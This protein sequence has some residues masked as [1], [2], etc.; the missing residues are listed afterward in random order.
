MPN[1][2]LLLGAIILFTGGG[3]LGYTVGH[4]QGLT[5]VGYDADAQQLVDVVKKQKDNLDNLNKAYNLAIQER[6]LA[7]GNTD[8]LTDALNN[9][10]ADLSIAQGQSQIYRN[11]LKDRGGLSLTIQNLSIQ[12]LPENA[13]EYQLDLVQASPIGRNATGTVEIR[14]VRGAEVLVVPMEDKNFNFADFSRLTGRWTMPKGFVPQYIEVRV[15]G[16]VSE[17]KRFSWLRGP[18]VETPATFVSEVPQ[19]EAKSQ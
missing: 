8:D 15:N 9:A 5:V 18:E 6:D 12:P 16:S 7:V 1:T 17:T 14:L 13:Y 3:V 2:Y 4:R 10:K 19:A 11:V